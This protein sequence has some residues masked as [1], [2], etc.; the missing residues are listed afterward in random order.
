MGFE[1][2]I[3]VTFCCRNKTYDSGVTL[4][5]YIFL[6]SFKLKSSNSRITFFLITLVTA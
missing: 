4:N 3:G 1:N 2:I 6:S 5:V